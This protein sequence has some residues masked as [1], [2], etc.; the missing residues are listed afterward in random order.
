MSLYA[1]HYVYDDRAAEREEMRPLHRAWMLGLAE[2]GIAKV[3][4]RYE[5]EGQPGALL[6]FEAESAAA[7]EELLAADPYQAAGLVVGHTVRDWPAG[8]PWT[9]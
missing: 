8:G 2:Q 6:V 7:V 9:A 4:G 5:D 1:I 3:F